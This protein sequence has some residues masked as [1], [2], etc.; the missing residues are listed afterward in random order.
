M[1]VTLNNGAWRQ[2]L[3]ATHRLAVDNRPVAAVQIA[4]CP[5]TTGQKHLGM[6]AEAM[7]D[8]ADVRS[9][10]AWSFFDNFEWA[11]GYRPRFGLVRVDYD[12]QRRTVKQSGHWFAKVCRER[13]VAAEKIID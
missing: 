3:I 7:R 12:T 13:T 11:S 9:Y 5:L 6:V 2:G 10:H 4:N 1:F 8:G